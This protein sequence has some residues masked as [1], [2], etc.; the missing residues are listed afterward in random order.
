LQVFR[1]LKPNADLNRFERSIQR[2][3]HLPNGKTVM[4]LIIKRVPAVS[5]LGALLSLAATTASADISYCVGTQSE[6][7]TALN[8]AEIDGD[9]SVVKVRSGTINLSAELRY[10]PIAEFVLPAKKLTMRG[11]YSSDCSSFSSAGG[12]TTFTSSGRRLAFITRTGGVSL[13]GLTLQGTHL[14]LTGLGLADITCNAAAPQF[15]VRRLRIDQASA[16]IDS[17]CHNVLV[18]NSLFTNGVATDND[19]FPLE[20]GTSLY[21]LLAD[22]EDDQSSSLSIINSSVINGFTSLQGCLIC[23]PASANLYNSI[24]DWPGTDIRANRNLRVLAINNRY[25]SIQFSNNAA[26]A[27]GS[28]VATITSAPALNAQ[29]VPSAGSPMLNSGSATVPNGLSSVDQDGNDRVVGSQVDRGALEAPAAI[30]PPTTVYTVTSSASVG[31][32]SLAAAVLLANANPGINKIE[33]NIPGSCPQRINL[34][35]RLLVREALVIDGW[36]QSAAIKNTSENGF[37]GRVCVILDGNGTAGTGVETAPTVGIGGVSIYGLAFEGFDIG[38]LLSLGENHVVQGS[39]FGGRI[40][41]SGPILTGNV[42]AITIA[43][44]SN[45]TIGGTA[46]SARNLI[47]DSIGNGIFIIGASTDGNQVIN[48]LIGLNKDGQSALPN[49]D[50]IRINARSTRV[51]DN[52]IGGNSRDGV[53]LAGNFAIDN[54]IV[55]NTIGG[56][57]PVTPN[58]R[59]GVFIENNAYDNQ[60]A[61]NVFEKNGDSGVRVMPTAGGHNRISFNRFIKNGA[62]GIDLGSDGVTANN[63][64]PSTCGVQ[65]CAA[66]REQNYPV[67]NQAQRLTTTTFP[68]N[69]PIRVQG[70]L[71]SVRGGP[72]RL[73]FFSSVNCF[74]AGNGQGTNYLGAASITLDTL[75]CG[76]NCQKSFT[77]FLPEF[78]V[79][80]GDVIT[81]TATSPEGDTSEFSVCE[82]LTRQPLGDDIF[83]NG[84]E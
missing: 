68:S 35:D 45:N 58:V 30:V 26:H 44:S 59:M 78:D 24:F 46:A 9:D 32:G 23:A 52:Q 41:D 71:S 29:F 82:T 34:T 22:D 5:L 81:A 75:V 62:I 18:D 21:V 28:P 16:Q 17:V 67:L 47:G 69:R 37:N 14:Y 80:T 72:Y 31:S 70:T 76:A 11:G 54:Q 49:L 19:S 36:T 25:D 1:V 4:P 20:A 38:V 33:F 8:S 61:A 27:L 83:K 43:G 65:G 60:I 77:V 55:N 51:T 7:Q 12:A 84:F 53:V 63:T 74:S 57:T 64:D 10:E 40:G 6:L 79:Q 50:G 56:Q 39:Q 3:I 73:E 42:N 48:N 2:N 15:N 13:S 66:N